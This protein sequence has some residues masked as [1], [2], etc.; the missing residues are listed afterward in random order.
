[1]TKNETI[2]V[3]PPVPKPII[4]EFT[5]ELKEWQE[6]LA[7]GT[8]NQPFNTQSLEQKRMNAL[9]GV[10][11]EHALVLQGA[12]KNPA[13]F[14]K[15]DRYSYCWDV[16]WHNHLTEVKRCGM[17]DRTNWFTFYP[18]QVK[19][20]CNNLDIVQLLIVGDYRIM[21]DNMISVKWLLMSNPQNFRANMKP[22]KIR[23]AEDIEKG[24][25]QYYYNHH[26]S[27]TI[28]IKDCVNV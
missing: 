16:D 3:L 6:E 15:T 12:T 21:E 13:K 28:M 2:V 14:D 17:D 7:Q 8:F 26:A 11:L 1:M 22:C 10:F 18:E 23:S 19:T 4:F 20:M 5:Q 9:S 24:R 27:K 25:Q